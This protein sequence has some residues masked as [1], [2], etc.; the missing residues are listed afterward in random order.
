MSTLVTRVRSNPPD[1]DLLKIAQM[2]GV[3]PTRLKS[4]IASGR[5]VIPRSAVREDVVPVP[6]GEGM[7][8]KINA[9]LGSSKDISNF[10]EEVQ[11]ARVALSAGAH[12]I[13]D[14]STG[15]DRDD[16]RRHLISKLSCPL[17]TVPIYD[18]ALEA[19]KKEGSIVDINEDYI[20]GSIEKHAKDGVDFLTLH[21][22][23]TKRTVEVLRKSSRLLGVVSRGGAFI[24][25]SIIHSGNENPLYQNYDYVLDLAE[26]YDFTISIGDGL[27]PGCIHDASDRAQLEELMVAAELV[28]R[29]RDRGVQVMVEG[30]GHVPMDQIEA[31]V[32]IEKAVCDGAPFYVLGPLVTDVAPGYDHITGAIG[33]ALAAWAGADFLCIVTPAE[34]ICLPTVEDVRRGV[35]AARIAAHAAEVAR[36]RGREWDDSI[37]KARQELDWKTH[38]ELSIDPEEFTRR[39]S[40]RPPHDP[41]VC[42]MCS[43]L[44]AIRLLE[45]Y[46]K[47]E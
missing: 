6:I 11:K 8:V 10:E 1:R 26:K 32:R 41:R 29:A 18:A 9:N 2:E 39:R 36:G 13:M 19:Q 40:M 27:R 30:P 12:T 42:S 20:F 3:P 22:A 21:A 37:S 47:E 24:A 14:L 28:K 17:G 5:V 31:N 44:C 43:D 16:L 25:A 33:G 23:V 4:L 35:I 15:K 34:H 7:S 46:L 45:E 38:M